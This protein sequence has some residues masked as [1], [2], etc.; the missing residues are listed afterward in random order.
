MD[1][2]GHICVRLNGYRRDLG[3]IIDRLTDY[4]R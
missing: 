3:E 1:P 4:Q 2:E